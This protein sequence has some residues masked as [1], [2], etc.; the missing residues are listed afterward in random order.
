MTV[1]GSYLTATLTNDEQPNLVF[2]TSIL[3]FDAGRIFLFVSLEDDPSTLWDNLFCARQAE[4]LQF[5]DW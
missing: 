3:M 5:R 4:P 1:K 2:V